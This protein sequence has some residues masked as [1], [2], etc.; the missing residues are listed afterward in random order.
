MNKISILD[1]VDPIDLSWSFSLDSSKEVFI[2]FK[3]TQVAFSFKGQIRVYSNV[4]VL[5]G[6]RRSIS[7]NDFID[8]VWIWGSYKF[9]VVVVYF[10][11]NDPCFTFESQSDE[12]ASRLDL[13]TWMIIHWIKCWGFNKTDFSFFSELSELS[14]QKRLCPCFSHSPVYNMVF[15]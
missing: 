1:H 2:L 12:L 14:Q 10:K 11:K 9:S 3:S 5:I 6:V 7:S 8:S 4:K 15:G 13:N